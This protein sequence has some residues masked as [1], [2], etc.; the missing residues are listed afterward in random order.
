MLVFCADCGAKHTIADDDVVDDTFQLRCDACDFLITA[1]SL[2][3]R[4][5]PKQA[6]P[7]PVD[8][9]MDLTCSHDVLEFGSVGD[10]R[11]VQTLILA[12]KDGRKVDLTGKLDAKLKGNVNLSAVSGMA[13]R[14]EV[15]SPSHV[16]GS[17]LEM[18][19]GP[20]VIITDTISHFKKV[21]SLSFTRECH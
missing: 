11:K 10:K 4:P 21:V 15:V 19:Q 9:T 20:G 6:P 2:P 16:S 7:K 13:F 14:V 8:P 3:T 17:C 18:Y 12:A 1:K 5:K